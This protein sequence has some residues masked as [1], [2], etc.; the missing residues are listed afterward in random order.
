MSSNI[1]VRTVTYVR[2]SDVF[3]D[4]PYMQKESKFVELPLATQNAMHTL[5]PRGESIDIINKCYREEIS[6]FDEKESEE[7]QSQGE[8]ELEEI[9]V[10]G[11]NE[12]E[13]KQSQGE[14]KLEEKADTDDKKQPSKYAVQVD[15]AILRL[16]TLSNGVLVDWKN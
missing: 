6:V 2:L 3:K 4:L 15:K 16:Q 7:K 11:E 12:S 8:E 9:F 5:L 14:E 13:E 1:P 10:F